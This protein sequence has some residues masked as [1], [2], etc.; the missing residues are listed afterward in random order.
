MISSGGAI[1]VSCGFTHL[2]LYSLSMSLYYYQ[3]MIVTVTRI[4]IHYSSIIDELLSPSHCMFFRGSQLSDFNAGFIFGQWLLW[5]S[6][7]RVR[8]SFVTIFL[9]VCAL[10]LLAL[11]EIV[12]REALELRSFFCVCVCVLVFLSIPQFNR[13]DLTSFLCFF[14]FLLSRK[15]REHARV[16]FLSRLFL[17]PSHRLELFPPIPAWHC[18]ILHVFDPLFSLCSLIL[19]PRLFLGLSLQI[20][21]RMMSRLSSSKCIL[22]ESTLWRSLYVTLLYYLSHTCPKTLRIVGY[23]F[24]QRS[25]VLRQPYIV[26]WI[27]HQFKV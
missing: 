16:C 2:V 8:R 17:P 13:P 23:I 12:A 15:Y 19:R 10:A 1:A 21:S 22:P 27:F 7:I 20:F 25:Y 6:Y 3:T 14:F 24:F 11:E 18:Y 9:Y 26:Y 4:F 5:S